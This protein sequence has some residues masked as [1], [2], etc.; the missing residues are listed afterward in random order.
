VGWHPGGG[1][2][3]VKA[4]KSDS[5]SDS[6]EKKKGRQVFQK[7]IER[8]HPQ[9]PPRVSPTLVTPL[10]RLQITT[11]LVIT[12][13]TS[14]YLQCFVHLQW[15]MPTCVIRYYYYYYYYY[16]D[17]PCSGMVMFLP[18]RLRVC[19]FYVC[20]IRTFKSLHVES[21]SLVCTDIFSV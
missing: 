2:T 17:Q 10:C 8:W 15:L 1:D 5:D 12:G 18:W 20:N 7:K 13:R 19:M 14:V 21:L 11:A 16:Y 6:D 3:R 4:I 9:L